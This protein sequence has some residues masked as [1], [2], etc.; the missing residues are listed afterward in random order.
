MFTQL[1]L[2]FKKTQF[3]SLSVF[4]CVRKFI[5]SNSNNKQYF[6]HVVGF[7]GCSFIA[8]L[9]RKKNIFEKIFVFYKI[10]IICRKI[11]FL[12]KKSFILKIFFTEKT[13][14]YREKYK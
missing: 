7:Y 11:V 2:T 9:S 8:K 1:N 13:F 12:R 5:R 6:I 10:Y 3:L 4:L 14:F